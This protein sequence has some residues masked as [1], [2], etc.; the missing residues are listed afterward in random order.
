MHFTKK[1]FNKAKLIAVE[2]ELTQKQK[3]LSKLRY[4]VTINWNIKK[5]SLLFGDHICCANWINWPRKSK[6]RR[7]LLIEQET[8]IFVPEIETCHWG[9]VY[10]E[11]LNNLDLELFDN[12]ITN[13]FISIYIL[14]LHFVEICIISYYP[15]HRTTCNLIQTL[16]CGLTNK[17]DD[18]TRINYC[19]HRI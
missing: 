16:K 17:W 6:F 15:H 3:L 8:E 1:K 2:S 10:L 7:R 11:Y 13:D 4:Q 9:S 5:N 18:T 12:L 19:L 14:L